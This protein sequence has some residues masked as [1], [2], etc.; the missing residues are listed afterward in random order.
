MTLIFIA[1]ILGLLAV[2]GVALWLNSRA[3]SVGQLTS[4]VIGVNA[5]QIV[6]WFGRVA[7]AWP[8]T[9][10]ALFDVVSLLSLNI[11]L[12]G[13]ECYSASSGSA[14][15]LRFFLGLSLPGIV[16][17]SLCFYYAMFAALSAR[18]L[19]AATPTVLRRAALQSAAQLC[20]VLYLPLC[21]TLFEYFDCY[22][23]VSE[24]V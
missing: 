7:I 15:F 9:I 2:S 14:F 8:P 3:D 20:L 13:P 11:E 10:R 22:D 1:G 6:A 12:G 4:V 24:C 17:V 23:Q 16:I 19:V 21:S 5:L 18:K